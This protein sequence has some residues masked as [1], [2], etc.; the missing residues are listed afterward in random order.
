VDD[1]DEELGLHVGR[2]E[3]NKMEKIQV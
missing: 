1:D 2:E 3:N